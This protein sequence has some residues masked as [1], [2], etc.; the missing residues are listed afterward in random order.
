MKAAGDFFINFQQHTIGYPDEVILTDF[1]WFIAPGETWVITGPNGSGKSAIAAALAGRLPV[2]RTGLPD[3]AAVALVS[4]EYQRDVIMAERRNDDSDFT[5]GG[6]DQGTTVRRFMAALANDRFDELVLGLGIG[7]LLDRGIK[8]LSTGELR[9]V[10][11]CRDLLLN[12]AWLILDEVQEGLDSATRQWLTGY[13]AALITVGQ[14][15]LIMISDRYQGL[16]SGVSHVLHLENRRVV[17][18]GRRSDYEGHWLATR[19][20]ALGA[21]P[22]INEVAEQRELATLL[23]EVS[24]AAA[25]PA[26]LVDLRQV[27][28]T[29]S[30]RKVLDGLSWRLERGQHTLVRGPNGCGKTTLLNLISGDNPQV[31]AN[32]VTVLGYRRG[33]GESIWDIK[34]Q[35]G[36]VSYQLHLEYLYHC[37]STVSEVIISGFHDSIGLYEA[38]GDLERQA[39]RAWLRH[40]GL[41]DRADWPFTRLSYGEQRAVLIAR[42]VVKQPPLLILDEPCHGLDLSHRHHALAIAEFIGRH[43]ATTI[44]YVTH[45]PDEYLPCL[46]RVLEYLPDGHWR[47]SVLSI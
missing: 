19:Q 8:Y 25:G 44:L 33:S 41:A 4:F 42:A 22:A 6:V 26:I 40:L 38:L 10:A 31:Y 32:D 5:E 13:L 27:T 29:W 34:R 9:K 3:S 11:L 28:V 24:P 16:P 7:H 12:P 2:D 21:A 45:D 1:T 30:G 14:P 18:A 36:L 47:E 43:T 20:V 46:Q 37:D 23:D 35:I 17:F 15:R 39:A